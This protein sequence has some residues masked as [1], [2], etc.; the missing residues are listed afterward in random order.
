MNFRMNNFKWGLIPSWAKDAAFGAKMFNARAETIAEKPSFKNSFRNRRCLVPISYYYEWSPIPGTKKKLPNQ[1]TP[2]DTEICTL[3]GL[4]DEWK[5]PEGIIIKSLTIITCPANSLIST[6]H[7][8]MPAIIPA[9]SRID[10]LDNNSK[11][12]DLITM[13]APAPDATLNLSPLPNGIAS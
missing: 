13:L 4:W 1:I 11:A 9:E 6:I 10:W 12:T 2:V 5:S 7:D 8:R 3:A